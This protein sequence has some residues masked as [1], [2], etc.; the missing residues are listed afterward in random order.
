MKNNQ[1]G[2]SVCE[3]TYVHVSNDMPI[4]GQGWLGSMVFKEKESELDQISL[5]I[6]TVIYTN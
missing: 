6:A 1:T 4:M 2:K 3:V 5:S